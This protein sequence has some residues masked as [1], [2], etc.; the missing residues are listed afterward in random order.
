MAQHIA[1]SEGGGKDALRIGYAT[2]NKRRKEA[3]RR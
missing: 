2:V 3:R 1:A